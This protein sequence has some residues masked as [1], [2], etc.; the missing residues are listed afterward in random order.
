[1]TAGL[2]RRLADQAAFRG[3][4]LVMGGLA[5]LPHSVA[6]RLAESLGA[7][8]VAGL[9]VT[10][11]RIERNLARVMPHLSAAERRRLARAVGGHFGRVILEYATL[12]RLV[13]RRDAWTLGGPGLDALRRA[14]AEGR[15][16]VLVSAHFGNWEVI[17]AALAAA[18]I[19]CGMIYRAFNNRP[20]DLHVRDL[21]RA[22]GAPVLTKGHRGTRALVAHVARGGAGL[23]LVDQKQT[24]APRLPFMGHPAETAL[25]AAELATR[26]GVPL[27]PAFATRLEDPDRFAV[28][29]EAPVP[30]GPASARM[31]EVNR[32]IAARIAARPGQWFW[33]H[34][35][36]R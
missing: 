31:E 30:D 15:G 34:N 27:L 3:A 16:A 21:M 24:G 18:G 32:R 33:L 11:R 22:A 10:R 2:G 28:E 26:L 6:G 5:L 19:P 4:R 8:I 12:P 20:F 13:A 36:W 1:M 25:A 29:I 7:A 17:R 14:R 35:R 23:I 9:P